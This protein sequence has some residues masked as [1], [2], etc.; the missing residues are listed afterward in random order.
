MNEST[1]TKRE[2]SF[3][4]YLS[5]FL[6]FNVLAAVQMFIVLTVLFALDLTK[7]FPTYVIL[8]VFFIFYSGFFIKDAIS[9]RHPDLLPQP[10]LFRKVWN[11]ILFSEYALFIILHALPFDKK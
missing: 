9:K 5:W 11:W 4:V 1:K 6:S 8:L 3:L 7:T 10:P 2:H